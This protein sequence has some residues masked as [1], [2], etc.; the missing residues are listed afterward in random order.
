MKGDPGFTH[1]PSVRCGHP[2]LTLTSTVCKELGCKQLIPPALEKLLLTALLSA[3]PSISPLMISHN[4]LVDSHQFFGFFQ[5]SWL[6]VQVDKPQMAEAVCTWSAPSAAGAAEPH[7]EQLL[8]LWAPWARLL[9]QKMG[10]TSPGY[11]GAWME[12]RPGSLWV[13]ENHPCT[14]SL[15]L[16]APPKKHKSLE[17]TWHYQ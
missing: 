3:L 13:R 17:T 6:V 12:W 11:C 8:L 14:Q 15:T 10:A 9:N 5:K 7:V 2:S 16:S 1:L 4:I